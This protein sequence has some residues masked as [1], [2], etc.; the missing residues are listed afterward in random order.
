MMLISANII[1]PTNKFPFAMKKVFYII[2]LAVM[3]VMTQSCHTT[4]NTTAAPSPKQ[5]ETSAQAY[6]RRVATN[7][8]SSQT[9]TAKLKLNLS[10]MGKS[11]ALSGTLRM[12]R[13][14]VIQLSASFPLIG[15][16]GRMEFTRDEVLIVDR[17]NTRYVRVPYNKVDFL[18]QAHLDFNALE[19]VFW[20]EIFYPGVA[21]VLR[22]SGEFTV[23][24]SGDH[25]LLSLT[26]APELDYSFLTQTTN[27]LLT[28]TTIAPKSVYDQASLTCI[29]GDFQKFASGKF[30]TK[31][32]LT[33]A[34]KK[35]KYGLDMS[36]SALN[37]NSDWETRTKVSAK[38]KQADADK[39]LKSLIE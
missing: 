12:K 3:A 20:N 13:G 24:S 30:P 25:T 26:T 39:L 22:K 28:R 10:G 16:V 15:E 1:F 5:Q 38:Y 31:I 34:G 17:I 33:F 29:Y 32:N 37:T 23:A 35:D 11:V 8:S 6:V 19:S 9:L 21:D 7:A 2:C 4:K 36:L 18:Q 14:D 27:A